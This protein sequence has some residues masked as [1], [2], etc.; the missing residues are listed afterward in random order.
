MFLSPFTQTPLLASDTTRYYRGGALD[1]KRK[2][3]PLG[4][5]SPDLVAV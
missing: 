1:K 5:R 2:R 3:P 4:R